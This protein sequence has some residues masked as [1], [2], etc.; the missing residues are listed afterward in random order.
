MG[1]DHV[2]G[3]PTGKSVLLVED[4]DLVAYS[5]S[6]LLRSK[7]HR[8]QVAGSGEGALAV[9]ASCRP[10]VALVDLNLP[11]M[12]GLALAGRFREREDLRRVV[13]VALTGRGDDECREQCRRAGFM[14]Y[15]RKPV[16]F[17]DIDRALAMAA[18]PAPASP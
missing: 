12:D 1:R 13:L 2:A 9:A 3:E 16:S 10:D 15:L 5:L 14:A 4:D 6:A 7:G 11:G 18:P 17:E 8:V